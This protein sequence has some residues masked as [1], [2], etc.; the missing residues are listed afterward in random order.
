MTDLGEAAYVP[1]S[2][3]VWG[4]EAHRLLDQ[5]H[6]QFHRFSSTPDADIARI[7]EDATRVFTRCVPT[8]GS[9]RSDS[10]LV[11]GR[12]Q[13]GKT[14]N[15]T[16]VTGLARDN[17]YQLFIVLAGTKSELLTQT[18][19]RLRKTLAAASPLTLPAFAVQQLSIG[20]EEVQAAELRTRLASLRDSS[21]QGGLAPVLVVL[22][23]DDNLAALQTVLDNLNREIPLASVPA[24]II[25]DEADQ[26]SPDTKQRRA[27]PET[28]IVHGSI[29]QLRRS[30][31]WHTFLAYTA[32]PQANVLMQMRGLLHPRYVTVIDAG[33][34]YI[35]VEELFGPRA[36]DYA[37]EVTDTPP[38]NNRPPQSLKCAVATFLCQIVLIRRHRDDVLL[39]PLRSA[40]APVTVTMLVNPASATA[41]HDRWRGLVDSVLDSWHRQLADLDDIASARLVDDYIRPA[42][43]RLHRNLRDVGLGAD[44]PDEPSPEDV[45]LLRTVIPFLDKRTINSVTARAGVRLPED[46]E[47]AQSVGWVLIGGEILGRG[48]TLTNL[49]T[50]YM[51]RPGNAAAIDTIQQRG[52]FYGYH[53]QYRALLGGWFESGMLALYRDA[54]GSEAL[55]LDSL[56]ELDESAQPLASWTRALLMGTGRL[57]ATRKAVIPISARE[58]MIEEWPFAQTHILDPAINEDNCD[59]LR[60]FVAQHGA[61]ATRCEGDKRP[62]AG[63]FSF[64]ITLD[65]LLSLLNEWSTDG[66]EVQGLADLAILLGALDASEDA[67]RVTAVLMDRPLDT[68]LA[69]SSG[70]YRSLAGSRRG[71]NAVDARRI[72]GV[73]AQRQ[74]RVV[75]ATQITVQVHVLRVGDTDRFVPG[76]TNILQ[77]AA[78]ALVVHIPPPLR[79]RIVALASNA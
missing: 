34:D 28:S 59:A 66:T 57:R 47:W 11:V 5:L 12:V 41:E 76:V 37:V 53:A 35:G 19:R 1:A 38:T 50:T 13:A 77:D 65:D 79:Q 21:T 23:E 60:R 63:D 27:G 10:Q 70:G 64:D 43:S 42:W 26:A 62:D 56:R 25:D 22:K 67:T 18:Y 44:V 32:T 48:Q 8:T 39:D 51:P 69:L 71:G 6:S 54:A 31:P 72:G 2:G 33:G 7:R 3:P 45:A 49:M 15:F 73:L 29:G 40:D 55:L 4:S 61:T 78:P 30:L 36:T 75:D 74:R 17:G 9:P 52:R 16:V 68:P 14:S 20:N 58:L 46:D 24:L